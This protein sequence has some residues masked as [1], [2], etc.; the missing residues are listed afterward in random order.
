MSV[1]VRI[2]DVTKTFRRGNEFVHVLEALSLELPRGSVTALTGPSGGG[3]SSLLN[4][5]AGYDKPDAGQIVVAGVDITSAPVAQMDKIRTSII[6]FIFQQFH[7][8]PQLT[9]LQNVE[10]ALVASHVPSSV[11][12]QRARDALTA[13]GLADHLHRRPAQLSGGQQQRVAVARALVGGPAIVLADEPTAALDR[14]TASA[15]LDLLVKRA[16]AAESAVLIAT[17]D[18]YA[19]QRS[20]RIVTIENGRI[21]Q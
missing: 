14:Q 6:G 16:R 18:P 9:S 12:C 4:L 7:L 5:I 17:H 11:R 2:S 10:L 20:D 19:M 21:A 3:K 15:L 1:A 13:V 8:V